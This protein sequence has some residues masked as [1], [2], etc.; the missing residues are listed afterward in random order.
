MGHG[1]W[2]GT[3][4]HRRVPRALL[5]KSPEGKAGQERDKKPGVEDEPTD[6]VLNS[7]RAVGIGAQP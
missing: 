7:L 4:T 6:F 1:L 2:S 3:G 5:D